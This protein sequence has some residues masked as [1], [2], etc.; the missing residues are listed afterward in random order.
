MNDTPEFELVPL[1]AE[2]RGRAPARFRGSRSPMARVAQPMRPLPAPRFRRHRWGWPSGLAVGAD[3]GAAP[4]S[5]PPSEAIRWVQFALNRTLGAGLPTDGLVSPALR[6]ALRA[7]Q[8]ERGLPVSGF[9]GPDT[10]AALQRAAASGSGE[11][12]F[13]EYGELS[14]PAATAEAALADKRGARS[15]A[16]ALKSLGR[17]PVPGLYRFFHPDGRF[18]TGISVDLR[19]RLIQHAWCLSH[20]GVSLGAYRVTLYRLPGAD[21]AR[22]RAVETAINQHHRQSGSP[23]LNKATELEIQELASM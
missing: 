19:R 6:A 14:G 15:V 16:S 20:F 3:D 7:F 11:A 13:A 18:Y 22:L 8:S 1:E 17:T 9:I 10:L 12:E 5:S 4:A 2:W 23:L 21:F